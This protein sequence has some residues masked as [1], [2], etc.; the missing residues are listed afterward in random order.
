M[1]LLNALLRAAFDAALAPFRGLHPLVGLTLVALLTSIGM[2]LVFKRTSA[3]DRLADVKRRIHAGLFEIR[4]FNDDLRAIMRAQLD[5]L[6]AN[7]TYLKLSLL[8]MIWVIP[9]LTLVIAQL[10]FHYGY[11]G[12]DPGQQALLE[13]ELAPEAAPSGSRPR[14]SLEVPEGL[15]VETPPL[16]IPSRSQLAWRLAAERAGDYAVTVRVGEAAE[17]KS[18]R[19]AEGPVRRSPLRVGRNLLDQLLY[20]AEPP[21]PGDSAIRSISLSYPER[22]MDVFGWDVHWMIVFFVLTL[23]FAFALR[24]PLGVT[25]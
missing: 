3:Q 17:T 5:I 24:G 4:L 25:I 20:P 6:R 22:D 13:V 7:L 8:P 16:W 12:L 15:R 9:P 10:Q 18:V 21:L 14:A 2:L 19:V 11:G 1:S 23:V